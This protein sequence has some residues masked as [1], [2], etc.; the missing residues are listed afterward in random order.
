MSNNHH[1][2]QGIDSK[3]NVLLAALAKLQHDMET[4]MI[5]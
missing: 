4:D 3:I 5:I 2:C 1:L